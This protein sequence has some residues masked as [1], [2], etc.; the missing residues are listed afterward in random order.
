V[1]MV[2][3]RKQPEDLHYPRSEP[4]ARH[5]ASAERETSDPAEAYG[6]NPVSPAS[7]GLSW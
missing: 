6:P 1:L 4:A 3:T 2:G 7:L 5:G